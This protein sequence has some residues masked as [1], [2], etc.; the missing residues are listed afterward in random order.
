[1]ILWRP[2]FASQYRGVHS[3]LS[4]PKHRRDL[5]LAQREPEE[6]VSVS[7]K[8]HYGKFNDLALR[9]KQAKDLFLIIGP[10]GTL[11]LLSVCSPHSK[12][13]WPKMERQ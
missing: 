13:P 10:P 12:R 4:A 6:D 7:L 9:V 5:L 1:M 3:V 8:G 11:R 2:R